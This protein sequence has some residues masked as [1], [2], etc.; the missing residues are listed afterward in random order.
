MGKKSRHFSA[1]TA[2]VGT[3]AI[4]IGALLSAPV[5]SALP[6]CTNTAPNTTQCTTNGSTSITTSPPLNQN[7]FYGYPFLGGW[8]GLV[9]GIG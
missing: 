8:S 7:N 1:L 6:E 4:G 5:A 9:V 2:A 3:A